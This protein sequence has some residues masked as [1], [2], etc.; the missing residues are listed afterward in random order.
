MTDNSAKAL[1]ELIKEKKQMKWV[2]INYNSK[3]S[4]AI[5]QEI[6]RIL[7]ERSKPQPV[8]ESVPKR[9]KAFIIACQKLSKYFQKKRMIS[10]R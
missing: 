8:Q 3:I 10:T 6:D 2:N 9:R 7:Q 5:K 1:L 4:E